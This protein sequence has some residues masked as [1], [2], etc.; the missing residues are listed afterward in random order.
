MIRI[1]VVAFVVGALCT[2]V[3]M[4]P[5]VTGAELP[6]VMWF[7]A[8]LMGAGFLLVLF[9]LLGNARTRSLQVRQAQLGDGAGDA[10]A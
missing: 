4:S 7:L 3:A 1:G 5:L 2:L 10:H 6:A 9:G 8:M